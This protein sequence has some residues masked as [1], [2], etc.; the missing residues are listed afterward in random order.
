MEN[1]S[2]RMGEAARNLGAAA[3]LTPVIKH[4]IIADPTLNDSANNINVDATEEKVTLRGHV[5]TAEMKMLAQSI[6]ERTLIDKAAKQTVDNQ[7][8]IRPSH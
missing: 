3:S 1:T 2:E 4:A 7:L 5:K 6:A 8:E